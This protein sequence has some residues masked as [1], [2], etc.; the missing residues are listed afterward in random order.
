MRFAPVAAPRPHHRV[1]SS[2]LDDQLAL[3]HLDTRRLHLLN[4]SAAAIWDAL[5]GADTIG[6]L[7]VQLGDRYEVDPLAIR[8]DVEAAIDQ[9]RADGLLRI[10]DRFVPEGGPQPNP[11]RVADDGRGSFAALD[12]RVQLR[13]DDEEIG[14]TIATI[15]APLR[16]DDAPT[17]ELSISTNDNDTWTLQVNGGPALTLS[18]KLS[19]VL[20]AVGELNDLA[21]ASVPDHLVFHAGAVA[22]GGRAV[23]LP[24]ASNHGKSTLTTAL[25]RDGFSY[26]TDEAAALDADNRVRPYPKAIALDPGS[27][28]LF[29][30]LAPPA[31]ADGLARAIGCRE[32]HVDP[33]R[34]GQVADTTPVAAVVC[35][36]WRAGSATRLTALS[37]DEALHLLLGEAFDFAAGGQPVFDRLTRLIAEVPVY[38]LGYGE[39]APAIA[40]VRSILEG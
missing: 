11:H 40:E 26:L 7:T 12:A 24:A 4:G 5:D 36:H 2:V 13:C 1:V 10:D 37:P 29:A 9:F 39:L 6:D 14:A 32:W 17:A 30:D 16:C 35:P 28:P 33:S 3:F 23:L 15:L 34:L 31:S 21:V 27:F 38:R 19:L 22:L 25:V 18:S 20:R 8:R